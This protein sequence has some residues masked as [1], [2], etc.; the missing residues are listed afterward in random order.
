MA[1]V[2]IRCYKAV[3]RRGLLIV[4]ACA[5]TA[6]PTV[7]AHVGGKLRPVAWARTTANTDISITAYNKYEET[8]SFRSAGTGAQCTGI[9]TPKVVSGV[10]QWRH[11]GCT[12]QMLQRGR[13]VRGGVIDAYFQLHTLP[14]GTGAY[15][16]VSNISILSCIGIDCPVHR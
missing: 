3:M 11:F 8:V 7:S 13:G 14:P 1:V 10:R 15:F 5:L 2:P 6:A 9:G 12:T 4:A 16:I